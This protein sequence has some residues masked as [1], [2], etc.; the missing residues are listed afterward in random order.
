MSIKPRP[1]PLNS[2]FDF[3]PRNKK[4]GDSA[5]NLHWLKTVRWDK[6][7]EM[8]LDFRITSIVDSA[9]CFVSVFKAWLVPDHGC[10]Q[11]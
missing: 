9:Q 3:G 6:S 11:G 7:H 2:Y 4:S 1:T 8:V 10:H 5:P